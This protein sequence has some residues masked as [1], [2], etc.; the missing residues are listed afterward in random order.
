MLQQ[1]SY[2][3]VFYRSDDRHPSRFHQFFYVRYWILWYLV[4]ACDF[5][6]CLNPFFLRQILV[7]KLQCLCFTF[8]II[9]FSLLTSPIRFDVLVPLCIVPSCHQGRWHET[10]G[11]GVL[12]WV[13]LRGCTRYNFGTKNLLCQTQSRAQ[14]PLW[15]P[16]MQGTWG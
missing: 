1:N 15:F 10:R 6:S 3:R 14:R 8:Q 2:L 13:I 16:G 4:V 11:K 9:I 12:K 5:I 7:F